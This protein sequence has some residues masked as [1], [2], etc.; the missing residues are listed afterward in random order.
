MQYSDG[1]E[2]IT[3]TP[4]HPPLHTIKSIQQFSTFALAQKISAAFKGNPTIIAA[5]TS[6]H[7][8]MTEQI[9]FSD[10]KHWKDKDRKW[11]QDSVTDGT[12]VTGGENY[13][14]FYYWQ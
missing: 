10:W 13:Y 2:G 5:A 7:R 9:Q 11:L 14:F 8:P 3:L 1:G 6:C 12:L 4:P